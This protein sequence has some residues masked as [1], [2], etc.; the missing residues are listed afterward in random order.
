M[1]GAATT[2]S[3][4]TLPV[5][6]EARERLLL[7]GL[8]LAAEFGERFAAN[9]AQDFCIAPLAM[10][11]ARTEAAFKHA[12][13]VRELAKYRFYGVSIE[14]E[15]IGGVARSKGAVGASVAANEFE[16]RMRDGLEQGDSQAGR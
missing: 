12:A 1:S 3:K 2:R 10:E 4:Q 14:S 6:E 15:T 13:F 5:G 7:D 11:A 9:L 8:D 16:N